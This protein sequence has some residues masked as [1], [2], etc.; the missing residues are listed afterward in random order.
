M[1]NIERIMITIHGAGPGGAEGYAMGLAHQ[2]QSR[3]L[4]V[5]MVRGEATVDTLNVIR[6]QKVINGLDTTILK[7]NRDRRLDTFEAGFKDRQVDHVFGRLVEEV[8]PDILHVVHPMNLSAGIFTEA[9]KKGIPTVTTLTDF[10]WISPNYNLLKPDGSQCPGPVTTTERECQDCLSEGWKAYRYANK[11]PGDLPAR[12]AL[13]LYR[14]IP[15]ISRL[16]GPRG[17]IGDVHE[18]LATLQ[19]IFKQSVDL[20]IAPSNY[21]RDRMIGNGYPEEKIVYQPH[22]HDLDWT[23]DV[24]PP[25]F[26]S[27]SVTFGYFGQII[28]IKGVD[29]L[30]KA[31]QGLNDKPAKLLIYGDQ[32]KNPTYTRQLYKL[33]QNNPNI[34]FRGRYDS[35]EKAQVFSSVDVV[36]VPSVW[37]E[38]N[39]LVIEEARGAQR[40][41]VASRLGALAEKVTDQVDGIL[42][43][44]KDHTDLSLK[45]TQLLDPEVRSSI[46]AANRPVKTISKEVDEIYGHYERLLAGKR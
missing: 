20:A 39:P 36:V 5:M 31:F 28:P 15:Q 16:R 2:F 1:T 23:K 4:E 19:A 40:V 12:T 25:Q 38:N 44:P 3:G 37:V 42:F 14:R 21:L 18:R 45:L 26:D 7:W 9:H 41:V 24:T 33:A 29:V 13:A 32:E 46:L 34:E 30:I 35:S 27:Q 8:K 43:A 10:W 17:N 22:G 6:T 11:L